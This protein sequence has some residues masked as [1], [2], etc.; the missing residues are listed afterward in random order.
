MSTNLIAELAKEF[1][2]GSH[3]IVDIITFVEAS[4]GLNF[5]LFPIQKFILRCLYGLPLNKTEKTIVVPDLTNEHIL[6]T[7][8]ET[9]MLAWLYAE[10]RC[11]TDVT[12]GKIFSEMI[13]SIGRRG[14]KSSLAACVSDYEFYKL[15]KRGNPA[16][17][18]TQP[19]T[20]AIHIL[21]VAPTDDQAGDLFDMIHT[22]AVN[23]PFLRDRTL[24]STM[25]YFDLQTDTDLEAGRKRASLTSLAGGCSSNGLRGKNAIVV[26]MDEMAFFID[27]AGR[28]S[29]E[30]V[31]K[32]L[33][34][35]TASFKRDGKTLLLSSPYAKYGKFYERFEASKNE[36]DTTLMF[37]MY[38]ALGNPNIA[39]EILI[40]K[41][42]QDRAS[43][44]C[45]FG[46]EFSDS[47]TAWIDDETEFK[48]CVSPIIPAARGEPDVAYYW[49]IDL[50]F[51]N[52]GTGLAIVHKDRKTDKIVLDHADVWFSASSDVWEF[53]KGIYRNCTKYAGNELIQ[54]SDI[55]EEVRELMKWFPAKAGIFD[56]HNGYALAEIFR[57]NQLSQFE[58][59]QFTET[60]NSE[61]FELVKRLYAERLVQLYNHPV[62]ISELLT[63]EA[64]KKAKI[65]VRAPNRRGAHDDLSTAYARAVW[66]CFNNHKDRPRNVT[67][68]TG[69]GFQRQN[70]SGAANKM[71]TAGSFFIK[72][73]Q[74]HGDHPRGIAG[75]RNRRQMSRSMLSPAMASRLGSM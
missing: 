5:K 58:M 72:Q 53:E 54:M 20:A 69:G 41:R 27:N 13:L 4:W 51:K 15:L 23:C 45:E 57:Q 68:G 10:G 29:G 43:F 35:S 7:L 16:E 36:P 74:M 26:I 70:L 62:L 18:Y 50:G 55:M 61:I 60:T 64:E 19:S 24:H 2:S 42:K 52:D 17:Y 56:Q 8:S 37:K 22:L 3:E 59:V 21:N 32:A 25:T 75:P 31:Y 39:K 44:M 46:G 6:F 71:E 40:T 11:N 30:E 49:G 28:F 9:E 1:I 65:K 66:T 47:I 48:Q 63:L 73:R 38:S 34:P 14:T 67:T 33:T 12:E